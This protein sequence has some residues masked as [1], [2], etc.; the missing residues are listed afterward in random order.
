MIRNDYAVIKLSTLF[1]SLANIGLVCK[2]NCTL[3]LLLNTGAVNV[4]VANPNVNLSNAAANAQLQYSSATTNNTFTNTCPFTIN[5]LNDISANGFIPATTT[6]IVAACYVEK[7]PTTTFAGVNLGVT[8]VSGSLSTCNT[9]HIY[10]SKIQIEPQK[11]L[12][13]VNENRNKK[14]VYRAISANEY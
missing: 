3:R 7:P 13:Y 4:I 10:Y 9:Q 8:R 11:A 5:Y 1:E 6:S 2:F 12:T 14:V